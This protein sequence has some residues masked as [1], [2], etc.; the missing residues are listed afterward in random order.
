[1]STQEIPI[2]GPISKDLL[3]GTHLDRSDSTGVSTSFNYINT[4]GS[5]PVCQ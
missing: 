4:L 2:A 5:G 3:S 1:M